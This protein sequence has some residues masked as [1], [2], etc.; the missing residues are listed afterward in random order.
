MSDL[1][2]FNPSIRDISD[3]LDEWISLVEDRMLQLMFQGQP[4]A[5]ELTLGNLMAERDRHEGID[6]IP[7]DMLIERIKGTTYRLEGACL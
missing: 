1:Y 3:R 5:K 4:F 2:H 6:R 7:Y